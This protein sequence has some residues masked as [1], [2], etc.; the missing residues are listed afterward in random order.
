MWNTCILSMG[1][2]GIKLALSLLERGNSVFLHSQEPSHSAEIAKFLNRIKLKT[3][4]SQAFSAVELVEATSQA[5]VLIATSNRKKFIGLEH[6]NAMIGNGTNSFP[7][8]V[9]VGKGCFKAEVNNDNNFIMR[10]DIGDELSYEIDSLITQ[11][12]FLKSPSKVRSIG[13]NRYIVR[14]VV[15]NTG[16]I[17]IDNLLTPSNV[18][19]KC[20]GEGNLLLISELEKSQIL[21]RLREEI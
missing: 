4:R 15:G 12:E 19:G 10:V 18:I 8:L 16:D 20:D 7:I 3:I 9:D 6:V 13:G 14:G 17:V 21:K 11:W 5:Q 2:I 1:N